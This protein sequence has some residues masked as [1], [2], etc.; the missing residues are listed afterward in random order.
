[1]GHLTFEQMLY[2]GKLAYLIL[3]RKFEYLHCAWIAKN[4]R[5]SSETKDDACAILV[6][7][8]IATLKLLGGFVCIVMINVL[9]Q[10]MLLHPYIVHVYIVRGRRKVNLGHNSSP[11]NNRSIK[12][13]LINYNTLISCNQ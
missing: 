1:M 4:M 2:L 13:M 5:R 9:Y 12:I 10:I 7:F 3:V 11:P 6:C 8:P